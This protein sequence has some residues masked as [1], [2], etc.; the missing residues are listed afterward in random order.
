MKN[1]KTLLKEKFNEWTLSV[2]RMISNDLVRKSYSKYS[3]EEI[4]KTHAEE[5]IEKMKAV[6]DYS[7]ISI[8]YEVE[9]NENNE[10]F[11]IVWGDVEI[12]S[13]YK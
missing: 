9:G 4:A 13:I 11:T 7:I 1:Q 5:I 8:A 10:D 12:I 3:S 6:Y 2:Q